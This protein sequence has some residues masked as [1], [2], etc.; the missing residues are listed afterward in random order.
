MR[1]LLT[2]IAVLLCAGCTR[3]E[4]VS[5][6]GAGSMR[7]EVEVYKGPLSVSSEAQVGQMVA[8]M[9]DLVRATVDWRASIKRQFGNVE[10]Q[11]CTRPGSDGLAGLDPRDCAML[12]SVFDSSGDVIGGACYIFE[13]PTLS[14]T[15]GPAV[16][17]PLGTCRQHQQY[18]DHLGTYRRLLDDALANCQ[19]KDGQ[20]VNLLQCQGST[21]VIAVENLASMMRTAAFRQANSQVAYISKDQQVRMAL[22]RFGY[23][24]SEYGN[25]IQGRIGVLQKQLGD[26]EQARNLPIGDYLRSAR[27]TDFVQLFDWLDAG[28]PS[29]RVMPVE[30]RVRMAERLTSDF[31]W[32]KVNEVYASGQGDVSMAFIKDDLGNWNLKS[33]SNDPQK[34]LGAYRKA[35]DAALKAVAKLASN[36][37]T[38]GT[39]EGVAQA[40]RMAA[41]ANQLATGQVP[42][43]G[44]NV[45]GLDVGGLHDRAVARIAAI[46][47]RFATRG[48]G[49][50]TEIATQTAALGA[51]MKAVA[52][53]QQVRQARQAAV[54][55]SDT[56]ES[57]TA[58]N[59]AT[60]DV[61]EAETKA[62][63]AQDALDRLQRRKAELPAEAIESLR[64]ALGDHLAVVAAMQDGIAAS[65]APPKTP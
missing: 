47:E 64:A 46:R 42:G 5:L 17:L 21:I 9:A 49:L 19:P 54:D 45:A 15:V 28:D 14:K 4:P 40:S 29:G 35:T 41:L 26:D 32:E 24:A 53:K 57:R 30:D 37:A 44:A 59:A 65:S 58:L 25:Q 61:A 3:Y 43:G 55:A 50:D 20:S 31:Y 1:T 11:Q 22:A 38:G 13:T 18:W 12:K 8:V 6:H 51:E 52:E 34:L 56:E 10:E 23:I 62:K 7:V 2:L 36:A 48:A 33:F 16:Y 39:V 60:L 63:T 27:P